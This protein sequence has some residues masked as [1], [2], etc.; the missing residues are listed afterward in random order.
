MGSDEK[1]AYTSGVR[2]YLVRIGAHIIGGVYAALAA[3]A[4][5]GLIG[6]GDPT[7]GTTYTL[8]AVTALVLGGST[9][10]R[11]RRGFGAILGS[12]NIY[13]INFIYRL[14]DLKDFKVLLLIFP[15]ERCWLLH[16]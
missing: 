13:L 1:S 12:L 14:L 10:W 4:F 8:M 16:Y 3:I 9:S 15:A 11:K 6:P 2:I 5:T 7:Q